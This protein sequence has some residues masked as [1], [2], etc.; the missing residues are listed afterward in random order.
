MKWSDVLFLQP[1]NTPDKVNILEHAVK[2]LYFLSMPRLSAQIAE[3]LLTEW[4][5]SSRV[6]YISKVTD[7]DIKG[8]KEAIL[9]SCQS[10]LSYH[11][12]VTSIDRI[13]WLA[14]DNVKILLW[15]HYV[16]SNYAQINEQ[17]TNKFSGRVKVVWGSLEDVL[18]REFKNINKPTDKIIVTD[19]KFTTF[20]QFVPM[21][22]W[23]GCPK[24]CEFCSVTT[25][26]DW[27]Y[28]RKNVASVL[29]EIDQIVWKSKF[30]PKKIILFA[31]DDLS[32]VWVSDLRT[33][34]NHINEKWLSWIWEWSMNIIKKDSELLDIMW[35]NC[36]GYLSWIEDLVGKENLSHSK[37]RTVNDIIWDIHLFYKH[38]MPVL[39]SIVLWLDDHDES[40]FDKLTNIIVEGWLIP[41]LHI[42]TPLPWTKWYDQLL[43]EGRI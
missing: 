22:I 4:W 7:N 15:W 28:K 26:I 41:S 8:T 42:A 29:E 17:I 38:N 23:R 3:T 43:Q 14:W 18:P 27:G 25:K 12:I 39:S 13:V 20:F 32:L 35:K 21:E 16:D 33:I 30:W 37:D 1:G 36:N 6:S 31:D 10:T 24:W 11:E 40:T 5:Y 2:K 19:Y 9:L 34:F